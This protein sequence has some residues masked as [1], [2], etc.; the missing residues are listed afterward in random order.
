MSFALLAILVVLF[1][2]GLLFATFFLVRRWLYDRSAIFAG[3]VRRGAR[4][5]SPQAGLIR[6]PIADRAASVRRLGSGLP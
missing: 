3:T 6:R 5:T 1:A 4:G 2:V